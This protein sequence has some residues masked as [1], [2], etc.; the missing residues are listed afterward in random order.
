M[1]IDVSLAGTDCISSYV[2]ELCDNEM[3]SGGKCQHQ[4]L[5]D[6]GSYTFAGLD[7]GTHY[8]YQ[9]WSLSSFEVSC[10]LPMTT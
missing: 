5:D 3:E 8:S 9:V 10:Q 2:L 1:V 7:H 4:K 6:S